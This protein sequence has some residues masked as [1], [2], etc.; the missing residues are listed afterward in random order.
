M[1]AAEEMFPIH[2]DAAD[3]CLLEY[4][5]TAADAASTCAKPL[6]ML[7]MY[8]AS[9][10]DSTAASAVLSAL[11]VEGAVDRFNSVAFCAEYG[12]GCDFLTT[13]QVNNTDVPWAS[14]IVANMDLVMDTWDGTGTLNEDIDGVTEFAG[15]INLLLT[16]KDKV[17]FFVDKNFGTF[18]RRRRRRTAPPPPPSHC[19]AHPA[20]QASTTSR[21]SSPGRSPRGEG[22]SRG[23]KTRAT[24]RTCSRTSA[25]GTSCA[26]SMTR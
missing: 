25:S 13:D 12:M 18:R 15:Y 19:A 14:G 5:S 24:T 10:W 26:S 11:K 3:W 7:N 4:E 16:R 23:S 8:Y 6:S 21:P 17:Y 9:A 20:L 2:E 22:R 1:R